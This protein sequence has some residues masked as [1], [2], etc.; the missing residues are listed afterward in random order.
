MSIHNLVEV[1]ILEKF[2]VLLGN[3]SK[4][5]IKCTK[6]NFLV[7]DANGKFGFEGGLFDGNMAAFGDF[8]ECLRVDVKGVIF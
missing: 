8:D 4:M 6:L 1:P 7:L 5:T 2:A 3:I